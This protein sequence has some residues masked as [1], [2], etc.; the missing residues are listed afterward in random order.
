ML[1]EILIFRKP[2][3]N[4][5][6]GRYESTRARTRWLLILCLA[7]VFLPRMTEAAE[8]RYTASPRFNAAL[9]SIVKRSVPQD[10]Q[11]SIQ[12]VDVDTGEVLME[13]NP[14]QPLVPASTLKVVTSASA[15]HVLGTGF[16]FLTEVLADGIQGASV[17]NLFLK[18]HGDPYL[19]TEELFALTRGIR[20]VGL[21]EVRGDI[22]VDD[23]FFLPSKP[24]DENEELGPRA[25][26]APYSALSLN[27]NSIK[28]IVIPGA[29]GQ[30]ASVIADPASEYASLEAAIRTVKGDLPAKVEITK[31]PG[32]DSREVIEVRGEIGAST[33]P[34]RRYTNVSSPALYTGW[35][36]KEFLLREGIRVSGK[37]IAGKVSHAARKVHEFNSRPLGLVVYGLNKFSNNFMA[38]QLCLAMGAAVHSQPGTREKGLAVIG[39][40]LRDCGVS[41]ERFHLS[42]ASGLSRDNRISASALVRVLMNVYSEFSYSPEFMASLGVA[43]VDGTLKEKFTGPEVR[44]RLRAKTGNLRGVNALTGYGI[45]LEGRLFAFACIVNNPNE[46]SGFINFSEKVMRGVLDVPLPRR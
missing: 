21:R 4:R 19:V 3:R 22:V 42:E 41:S 2:R 12:M 46:K 30:P 6:A 24:L 28:L 37:V 29:V 38:E 16:T 18:G 10:C 26:H 7:V 45:S 17:G 34:W 14:H 31:R 36:F 8:K 33:Q 27:F 5:R 43:G 35:V 9:N 44:G 40:F 15:L 11:I 1:E 13:K 32:S 25:Y 23:S 39:K 20:D